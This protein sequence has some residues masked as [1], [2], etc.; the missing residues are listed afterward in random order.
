VSEALPPGWYEDPWH[1]PG[2]R[3]WDGVRWTTHT[4]APIGSPAPPP[5]IVWTPPPQPPR[6]RPPWWVW[7]L[8]VLGVLVPMGAFAA[9]IIA[10]GNSAT[11][12]DYTTPSFTP[13]IAPSVPT[14]A[15][16]QGL[17]SAPPTTSSQPPHSL[18]AGPAAPGEALRISTRNG[19]VQVR[20]LD[21]VDPVD[22][23]GYYRGPRSGTRWVGV[24]VRIA[25]LSGTTYEDD[26]ANDT[27]LVAG[28]RTL[29]ADSALLT[30][31]DVFPVTVSIAPGQARSGCVIFEVPRGSSP[32]QLR[33]ASDSYFGPELGT[34]V[35]G[36]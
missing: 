12:F 6:R 27:R 28:G 2:I 9:I 3:W 29:Q 34:F 17:P 11:E 22:R 8:A 35:L 30:T 23:G 13:P 10:A 21:V 32:R 33:F 31:C 19:E 25:N 36:R 20:V 1:G 7:T 5:P 15:P 14:P 26:P 24:R 18:R 16:P 4:A